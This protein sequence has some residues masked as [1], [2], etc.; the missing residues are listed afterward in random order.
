M[1]AFPHSFKSDSAKTLEKKEIQ[2]GFT[3]IELISVMVILSIISL[4]GVGFV[5]NTTESYQRTQ[6]RALIANTA[7]QALERMTRQLRGA[8]PYSVRST[9]AGQC[10]QFMPIQQ[11]GHYFEPVPDLQNGAAGVNSIKA[12]PVPANIANAHYLAIG[13]M[14]ATEIY[15]ASPVSLAGYAGY[16]NGNL[17]LSAAKQWQRNSINKRFYILDRAQAFCLVGNELRFYSDINPQD[18]SVTLSA[19]SDILARNVASPAQAVPFTL[20]NGSEN[21]NALVTIALDFS[22]GSE[23]INYTQRVFVRNVP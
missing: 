16:L 20:A 23:T 5:V 19:A 1:R 18:T 14:N 10:V 4:I 11:G 21:S 22:G 7:R 13:A 6:T 12:S 9:N 8:L 15:G 17:R 3:L 2:S